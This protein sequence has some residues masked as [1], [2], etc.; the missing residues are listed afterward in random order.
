MVLA[1]FDL[2]VS[3]LDVDSIWF[4]QHLQTEQSF[5]ATK[6]FQNLKDP[7]APQTNESEVTPS[8]QLLQHVQ[9]F[10]YD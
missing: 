1:R 6:A 3:F 10:D 5:Q 4:Q 7:K 9:Q 8:K 2:H